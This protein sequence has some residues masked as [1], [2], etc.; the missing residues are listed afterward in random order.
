METKIVKG[1]VLS[2]YDF[3]EKD[4]LVEIFSVELGKI[5][6]LLKG[7]KAPTAKLK[8]AFQPF[9]FAEFSVI[10]NG[11]YYQIVDAKQIDSFFDISNDLTNYYLASLILELSSISVEFEEQNPRLFILLV[12]A[13]KHICYDNLPPYLVATKFCEDILSM[14]GYNVNYQKCPVCGMTYTGKVFLNLDS[15]E[16]VCNACKSQNT[17]QISN[18]AFALLKILSNTEYDRLNSIKISSNVSKEAILVICKNI[19]HR[20]LKI[21][22]SAKFI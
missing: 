3:K 4:K 2:S 10:R 14:L 21:I 20:L 16:F 22:H 15:G 17:I 9:C 6:C 5:V 19:E 7:C 18:Q 12:N 11:K 8:F 13:L 1:V